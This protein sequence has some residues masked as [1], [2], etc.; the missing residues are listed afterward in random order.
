[1][2]VPQ[3]DFTA[4]LKG[5]K[6]GG[7]KLP[8]KNGGQVGNPSPRDY[9]AMVMIMMTMDADVSLALPAPWLHVP[10]TENFIHMRDLAE[11]AIAGSINEKLPDVSELPIQKDTVRSQLVAKPKDKPVEAPKPKVRAGVVRGM[12]MMLLL[13]LLLSISILLALPV[14]AFPD[15][16]RGH[17]LCRQ[18][19]VVEDLLEHTRELALRVCVNQLVGPGKP[20]DSVEEL[21]AAV[22]A[23]DFSRL[24]AMQALQIK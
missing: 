9:L 22:L 17:P 4:M 3:M 16:L 11:G 8:T 23:G 10:Q 19:V 14:P 24:N 21:V 12:M 20:F 13:L 2:L 1:L 15:H 6:G 7:F 5:P 18:A